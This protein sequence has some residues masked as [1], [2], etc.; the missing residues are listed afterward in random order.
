MNRSWNIIIVPADH[1]RTRQYT[2]SRGLALVTAIL[3]AV[4]CLT[5]LVFMMNYS[6]VLGQSRKAAAL[7]RENQDLRRQVATVDRL[8]RE[9]ENLT[10]LKAQVL[11]MLGV[12][13]REKTEIP[14]S[15]LTRANRS[16]SLEL[17]GVNHLQ[18][19]AALRSHAPTRWPVEGYVSKE[20]Y[21]SEKGGNGHPGLDLVA[22]NGAPVHAAGRGK[23]VEASYDES[24]G[25]YIVIDH[26]FG[27]STLYGHNQRLLVQVGQSVDQG[28]V[29]ARLGNTGRSSAPHLHFEIRLDGKSVDPR[30]YLAPK[31]P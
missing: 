17:L 1:S 27:Y 10:A 19:A 6:R 20:F 31:S 21:D 3:L 5:V 14:D 23:V 25:N 2:V 18:A 8:N 15:S 29:I 24:L 11:S 26:G 28:Q 30:Q 12:E 16:A 13:G 7:E 22:P 9:V 4:F